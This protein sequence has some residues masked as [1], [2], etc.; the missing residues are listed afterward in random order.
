[1]K[2]HLI[3]S[4]NDYFFKNISKKMENNPDNID[5]TFYDR[6]PDTYDLGGRMGLTDYIDFLTQDEVPK[7]VM[8][9]TDRYGRKFLTMKIGGIGLD[10]NKFF[11]SA[12]V[13]FQRYTDAPYIASADFEGMFIQTYGGATP[14]QYQLINDLVDGKVVKI[15]EEHRFNSSK[16][17]IMIANMDYWENQFARII[18][19]NWFIS[20]YNPRY[21]ICKKIVNRW[22]DEYESHLN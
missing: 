3:E 5:F 19:R 1:M 6:V 12:Q 11:R 16:C 9:G 10:G 15:K 7:N 14:P 4:E 17:N 13:F 2:K 18:Q 21:T 20:R 22:Y 8:K